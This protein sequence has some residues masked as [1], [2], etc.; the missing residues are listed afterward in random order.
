MGFSAKVADKIRGFFE[1][2]PEKVAARLTK[3]QEFLGDPAMAYGMYGMGALGMAGYSYG[4]LLQQLETSQNLMQRFIDYEEMEQYPEIST[5]YDI[6]ADDSTQPDLMQQKTMWATAKDV[7]VQAMLNELLAKPLDMENDV[8]ALSRALCKYGNVFGEVLVN[9]NGVV[10]LN[11]LPAPTV[12]R[13]ETPKGM[14]LG[15]IQDETGAFNVGGM[16]SMYLQSAADFARARLTGNVPGSNIVLYEDW[17]VVHWRLQSKALR[18]IYGFGIGEPARWI[19]RRLMLLEDALL[20]YKL[21]R[22]PSRYAFFVDTGNLDQQRA[23]AYVDQVAMRLK[24]RKFVNQ[25]T[26]KLDLA[27]NPMSQDEDF[28][29][30]SREGRDSTRVEVLSGA[31]YQSTGDV[32]YFQ[33]KLFAALKIPRAYLGKME[34]A[35]KAVLSMED[36]QFAR[37]VMRVQR[38]MTNGFRKVCRVHLSALGIDPAKVDYDLRMTVPSSIF[39]L[40]RMEVLSARADLAARMREYVPLSWILQNVFKFSDQ[41]AT[42]LMKKSADE[43]VMMSKVDATAAKAASDIENP[44]EAEPGFA[45]PESRRVIRRKPEQLVKPATR[46]SMDQYMTGGMDSDAHFRNLD[47]KLGELLA[48]DKRARSKFAELNAFLQEIRGS[49]RSRAA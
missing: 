48:N 38:E 10:G 6:Y 29:I 11:Y 22:A 1:R 27:Y 26:G 37:T 34:E 12:R 7:K 36:V 20:I 2:E 46:A 28:F 3:G 41:E 18:A 16:S 35:T 32:E 23:L 39:E 45:E 42:A 33:G 24:K 17:E 14:L 15:F 43:K 40:S 44:P 8:W 4:E 5:A 47:R 19:W 31:D 49:I 30:P 9:E 25:S 21:T 13:I